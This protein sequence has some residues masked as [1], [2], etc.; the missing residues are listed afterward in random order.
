LY[1]PFLTELI[2]AGKFVE[3][4]GIGTTLKLID[5]SQHHVK[6]IP[7]LKEFCIISL[8]LTKIEL[9]LAISPRN[10]CT[11]G[12]S[13]GMAGLLPDC[14]TYFSIEGCGNNQII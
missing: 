12:P 9:K 13:D 4:F 8:I 3:M 6:L 7:E 2:N 11:L 14:T 10:N 1:A 5:K